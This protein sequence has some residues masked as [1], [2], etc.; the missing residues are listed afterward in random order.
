[1]S[2]RKEASGRRSVQV[3]VE[4]PGT[5]EEVWQAIASGPGI[6]SWFVPAEFEERDGMPVAVKLNF[7]PGMESRSVVTAWAENTSTRYSE[8]MPTSVMPLSN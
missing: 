4:V 6:S 2:V 3:E 7:G 8:A 1:M 5:P